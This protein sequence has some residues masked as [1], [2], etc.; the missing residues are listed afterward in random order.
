MG[1]PLAKWHTIKYKYRG[2]RG[3]TQIKAPVENTLL[4][5]GAELHKG[6]LGLGNAIF[7]SPSPL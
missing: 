7:C 3:Y 5:I 6:F 1:V 2:I 4:K